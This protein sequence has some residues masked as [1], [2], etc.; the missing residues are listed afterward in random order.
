MRDPLIIPLNNQYLV[1]ASDNS[2]GFGLKEHD[3]VKVPYDVVGYYAFRVAIMECMATGAVPVS[4]VLQNF[5]GEEAWTGLI[6]GVQQGLKELKMD[7]PV[8]GSTESNMDLLQSALGLNVIGV[9]SQ[10][11]EFRQ[12]NPEGM[13]F[14]VIGKP[15]VGQEVGEQPE[16]IAPLSVYK[17]LCEL[18]GITVLPVG[19][20]GI[21]YELGQLVPGIKSK[22]FAADLDVHKS[23]GP[24]TCF[25]ISYPAA[26]EVMIQEL[27]G[28]LF[29]G[30]YW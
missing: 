17:R 9:S 16:S 13:K 27:T 7:L 19:S 20:K 30:V 22:C 15:L 28:P 8:S 3:A 24:S 4:V 21:A 10:M 5:S 14:A 2:G 25:I 26:K 1:V 18:G 11:P 12:I 23:S 29:H 6:Q